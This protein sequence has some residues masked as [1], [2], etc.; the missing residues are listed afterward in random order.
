MGLTDLIKCSDVHGPG[1]PGIFAEKKARPGPGN[2]K[3]SL[4]R[5]GLSKEKKKFSRI[6]I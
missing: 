5:A 3:K 2:F 4:T 6:T 1:Q